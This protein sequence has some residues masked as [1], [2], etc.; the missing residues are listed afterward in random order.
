MLGR[1]LVNIA[2]CD[3]SGLLDGGAIA[4]RFCSFIVRVFHWAVVAVKPSGLV[5]S[6]R[7]LL[8]GG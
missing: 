7:F 4:F 1:T 3:V 8:S 2:K 5:V 6:C